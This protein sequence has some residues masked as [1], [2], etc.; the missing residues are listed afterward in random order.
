MKLIVITPDK[1]TPDETA[2]INQLFAHGLTRL[3]IRKPGFSAHDNRDY[4]SQIAPEYHQH[5]VLCNS[6]ELWPEFHLGG[7]HLNS[8]MRHQQG[9]AAAVAKIEPALMS[10]SFHSWQEIMENTFPYGYVFISPVFDSISKVGYKAAIDLAGANTTKARFADEGK[11][12]PEL[13]G[14]GGV[15]E[16]RIT[17][18]HDYGFD[19][20]AMLGAIWSAADPVSAF[21][22][23]QKEIG[24]ITNH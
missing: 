15:E 20:C 21:I 2:I 10:T 17:A 12:C 8:H 23:A 11:Y 16:S 4:I 18:L 6:F 5:L 24:S 22:S 7:V 13:I 3:H 19:G 14:L 9:A 1:V